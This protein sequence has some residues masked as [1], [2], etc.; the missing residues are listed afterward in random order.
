MAKKQHKVSPQEI[1]N[2]LVYEKNVSPIHARGMIANI[3]SESAFFSDSHNPSDKGE[4]SSGLFQH[5]GGRRDE[6][7]KATGG[8]D[9]WKKDWRGQI[10]F[11]L[12]EKEG[13]DY[14]SKD[15][16]NDLEATTYFVRKF[17][18]PEDPHKDNY[19]TKGKNRL[20]K[21]KK[22]METLKVA[23]KYFDAKAPFITLPT[24]IGEGEHAVKLN[25]LKNKVN[26]VNALATN[27]Y[28][29]NEDDKDSLDK[30]IY[31]ATGEFHKFLE[32]GAIPD[33]LKGNKP[34]NDDDINR[35]LYLKFI[36]DR[37]T[38][39]VREGEEG[40]VIALSQLS[41]TNVEELSKK[42]AIINHLHET[43]KGND[44]AINITGEEPVWSR[45]GTDSK[46]LN[47]MQDTNYN[48]DDFYNNLETPVEGNVDE[49][50]IKELKKHPILGDYIFKP[51]VADTKLTIETGIKPQPGG[52]KFKS[53]FGPDGK[54]KLSSVFDDYIREN[55]LVDYQYTSD[56][57][58]ETAEKII[59][60]LSSRKGIFKIEGTDAFY[61]SGDKDIPSNI[62]KNEEDLRE[63]IGKDEYTLPEG[64][65][66]DDIINQAKTF[67]TEQ[68]S[69]PDKE[70]ISE[71]AKNLGFV[72]PRT[73]E[74]EEEITLDP[75][76]AAFDLTPTEPGEIKISEDYIKPEIPKKKPEEPDVDVKWYKEA[77][78]V[79]SALKAGAGI[80]SLA[81]G[82]KD[83][84]IEE[85]SELSASFKDY[86]NK[87]KNL[88]ETGLTAQEK[89]TVRNDL[90]EAYQM[91]VKNVLRASGGSR[92]T[93]L[94]GMGVLN[95]NRVKG[96]VKLGQLDA[97][98]Q[99]K[100]IELYGN[101][102][103]TQETLNHR[104]G[105]L[106]K[107]MAYDEAK[108]KSDSFGTIG[109][110]LIGSALKDLAYAMQKRK[111]ARY[112][113]A[114][115]DNLE[116]TETKSD[117]EVDATEG[118]FYNISPGQ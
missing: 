110:T 20:N 47:M 45:R 104:S 22:T 34:T 32:G 44:Y 7:I 52:L 53:D 97:A 14:I 1:Y 21:A 30:Q 35:R 108:R 58:V 74:I 57:A 33:E 91:G 93:F 94:A 67:T 25:N 72:I 89:S 5:R 4:P 92:G 78:N 31:D 98:Q 10:D 24:Q 86:M 43:T 36:Q 41:N 63:F 59:H 17:E 26:E 38:I 64:M 54:I 2:Y 84:P 71:L 8:E 112:S 18:R 19:V 85:S 70:T 82:M 95:A 106:S 88:S 117:I 15:F 96:L 6:M 102:L 77:T 3:K 56:K 46:L 42:R 37:I 49:E 100:N 76:G 75:R 40:A 111:N 62:F 81:Q 29:L 101:A 55:D 118:D 68:F 16:K 9:R 116:A 80:I 79:I 103:K 12:D 115:Y 11:A 66:Q 28:K 113:N 73:Q 87:V 51:T 90:S 65:S 39:K 109:S 13:K 69:D 61:Y 99:R 27:V 83:I 50:Y 60:P 23:P 105:E 48:S 107:K 114:V